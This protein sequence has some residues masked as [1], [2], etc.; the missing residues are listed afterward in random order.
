MAGIRAQS[1][2]RPRA[3]LVL[4]TGLGGIADDLTEV[5]AMSY[6][7]IPGFPHTAVAGHAGRFLLGR[8]DGTPVAVLEGRGHQYEGWD[9]ATSTWPVRVLAALGADTLVLTGACGG[10]HPLWEAGDL[11]LLADHLNLMGTTPLGGAHD[12][13]LGE[14]FPDLTDAWDG[15]L[16]T[17]ARAH[18]TRLGITLREGIY[19]AVLGPSLETRAEYRWLRASGADVVGMSVVP[20]ALAGVQAGMRL[21]GITVITDRCLPD[22]LEPASLEAILAAA[23]GAEPHLRRLVRAVVGELGA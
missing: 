22:A 16:R 7:A 12:P 2:L 13:V 3:G 18:A 21:L 20:E 1:D 10:M 4:G 17:A 11:V 6:D 5:V 19:A 14:R 9:A 23:A 15:G 8:L